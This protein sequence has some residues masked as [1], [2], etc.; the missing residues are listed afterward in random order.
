MLR[1]KLILTRP[2]YFHSIEGVTK[3][4]KPSIWFMY[5]LLCKITL[6][7]SVLSIS[8]SPQTYMS[9]SWSTLSFFSSKNF[10]YSVCS[11]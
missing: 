9:C 5:I 8:K 3:L 1:R 7:Y 6:L 10:S 11:C 2:N 4:T